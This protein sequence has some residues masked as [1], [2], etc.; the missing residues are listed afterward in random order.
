MVE[1]SCVFSNFR[2]RTLIFDTG[3]GNTK[4]PLV[5][6]QSVA[7]IGLEGCS[8]PLAR[9]MRCQVP[10]LGPLKHCFQS[11]GPSSFLAGSNLDSFSNVLMEFPKQHLRD[12]V[13]NSIQ[14]PV[15]FGR[16]LG[17]GIEFLGRDCGVTPMTV[18]C[19]QFFPMD[20]CFLGPRLS[21]HSTKS[22]V[23]GQRR[24][25]WWLG[26]VAICSISA[27]EIW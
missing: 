26:K 6:F 12:V 16:E 10:I 25:D 2:T 21:L 13:S 5:A 3:V 17:W 24:G 1:N 23:V 27:A 20:W 18:R 14:E 22:C 4:A 8:S 11:F 15:R 19:Q 7:R 9:C